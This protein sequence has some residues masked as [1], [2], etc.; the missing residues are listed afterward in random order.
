MP[1]RITEPKLLLGEGDEAVRLFAALLGHLAIEDVQVEAYRGRNE[2]GKY[3]SALAPNSEFRNNVVS[4]GITQDADDRQVENARRSIQGA[5]RSSGLLPTE[6]NTGGKLRVSLFVLPDNQSHGML[7][8]LCLKALAERP[9]MGCI[10]A[11]LECVRERAQRKPSNPAKARIHA[12][13]SSL[14]R[15]VLRLGEAAEKGCLPW[16]DPA[17]D[18]LKAFLL[19]R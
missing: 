3:L 11:Y 12:W 16:D 19:A 17:F 8:D 5:L 1:I 14:H 18:A 6:V 13:L 9:E 10:D 15:P 4:L 2:L 7:E